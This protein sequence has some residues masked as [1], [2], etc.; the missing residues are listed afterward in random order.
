MTQHTNDDLADKLNEL[1]IRFSELETLN[2]IQTVKIN[3]LTQAWNT[4]KGIVAVIRWLAAVG[5]GLTAAWGATKGLK[6]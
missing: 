4:A 5:A 1:L 3:E 6:L 2:E